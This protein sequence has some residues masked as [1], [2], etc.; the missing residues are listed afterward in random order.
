MGSRTG[1]GEGGKGRREGVHKNTKEGKH[2]V[3]TES[4]SLFT[5]HVSMI[6]GVRGKRV[7]WGRRGENAPLTPPKRSSS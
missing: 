2:L 4:H 7:G 6:V 1:Q 5:T 3:I